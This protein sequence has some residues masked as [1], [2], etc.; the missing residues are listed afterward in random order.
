MPLHAPLTP[1]SFADRRLS[2]R[3]AEL[4]GQP[5]AR[6]TNATVTKLLTDRGSCRHCLQSEQGMQSNVEAGQTSG[7]R[8]VMPLVDP[9]L[10]EQAG[11][12]GSVM[13]PLAPF[14]RWLTRS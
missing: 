9:H 14:V 5:F 2:D 7:E 4:H 1:C 10:Q 11:A 8:Q 13:A 6:A 3:L 12:P